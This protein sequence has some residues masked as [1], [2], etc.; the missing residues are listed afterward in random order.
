[1]IETNLQKVT[2]EENL[3]QFLLVLL[4]ALSVAILP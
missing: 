3:E 1:M 2:I 4:V